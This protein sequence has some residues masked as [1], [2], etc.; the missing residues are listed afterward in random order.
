MN[1]ASEDGEFIHYSSPIQ[2]AFISPS[3]TSVSACT[4][5]IE[6]FA[7]SVGKKKEDS[8]AWPDTEYGYAVSKA[9]VIAATKVIAMEI[10][11]NGGG[12]LF[13]ACCPG[14]F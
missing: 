1:V 3:K 9:G 5:L 6:D 14:V 4:A 13:N 12:V 11:K 7:A 8:E 10:E 2:Q